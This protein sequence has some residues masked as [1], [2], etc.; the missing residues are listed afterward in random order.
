MENDPSW[1]K[2]KVLALDCK[3]VECPNFDPIK[4]WIAD[5]KCY[6]LIR[7]DRN[8]VKIEVAIC[9]YKNVIHAIYRGI[10]AQDIYYQVIREGWITRIDHAAYFGKELKK[11]E[12]C[13][14]MGAEYYQE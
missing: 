1:V 5:P 9:D 4:D 3:T 7:L 2:E 11:A 10:R 8:E 12:L 14:F 13:L 6:I